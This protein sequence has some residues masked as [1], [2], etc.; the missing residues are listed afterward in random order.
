MFRRLMHSMQHR[1]PAAAA[2]TLLCASGHCAL[3]DELPSLDM[4]M[5]RFNQV[6]IEN[7]YPVFDFDSDGCYPATPF[8][9]NDNFSPNPGLTATGTFWGRSRDRGW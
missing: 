7:Y 3:S 9:K 4:S 1:A 6:Q 2:F 5:S 8:N